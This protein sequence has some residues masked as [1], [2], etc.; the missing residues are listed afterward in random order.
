MSYSSKPAG[1]GRVTGV[2]ITFDT[3]A[4]R[5]GVRF[6]TEAES[7]CVVTTGPD[8][9]PAADRFPTRDG[10]RSFLAK[11]SEDVECLF[12]TSMVEWIHP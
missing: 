2:G 1:P 10:G 5:P 8:D 3:A 6:D 12:V 11:D 9:M 4:L 7:G